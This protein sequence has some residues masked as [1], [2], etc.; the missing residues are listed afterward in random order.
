MYIG[1]GYNANFN[2]FNRNNYPLEG[3]C[4][5]N[6]IVYKNTIITTVILVFSTVIL[7]FTRIQLS[8]LEF[9]IGIPVDRFK[10]K[11]HI[12]SLLNPA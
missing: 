6:A 8:L 1:Y 5:F 9:Y 7:V 12:H 10:A 3:N 4:L 2:Y 11:H